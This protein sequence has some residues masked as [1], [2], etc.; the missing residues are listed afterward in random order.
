MLNSSKYFT[1][2]SRTCLTNFYGMLKKL[3]GNVSVVILMRLI[4]S[5][6]SLRQKTETGDYFLSLLIFLVLCC[7]YNF[8]KYYLLQHFECMFACLVLNLNQEF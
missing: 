7:V 6:N 8:L 4:Y 5:I 2:I 3:N 1:N